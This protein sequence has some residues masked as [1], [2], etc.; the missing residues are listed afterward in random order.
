MKEK[1]LDLVDF[2]YSN[3]DLRGLHYSLHLNGNDFKDDD[4]GKIFNDD[5]LKIKEI[6]SSYDN[7]TYFN[8]TLI[9]DDTFDIISP[10][11]RYWYDL[12]FMFYGAKDDDVQICNNIDFLSSYISL[13]YLNSVLGSSKAFKFTKE[14]FSN[15]KELGWF[16]RNSSLEA[17]KLFNKLYENI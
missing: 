17:E 11:N 16:Y 5:F 1:I 8:F 7:I 14:G 15:I 3:E 6:I 2:L 12:K 13:R 9:D 4:D 10:S